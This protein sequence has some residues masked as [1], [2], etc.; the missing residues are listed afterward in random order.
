MPLPTLDQGR[1]RRRPPGLEGAVEERDA[2]AV[3]DDEDELPAAAQRSTRRP[4]NLRSCIR[5]A[6][7]PNQ[8]ATST[9]E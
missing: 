4:A 1:D 6:R 7:R 2:K 5:R 9:S 3:D 8:A